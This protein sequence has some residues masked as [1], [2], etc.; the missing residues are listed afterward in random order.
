VNFGGVECRSYSCSVAARFALL[1]RASKGD[2]SGCVAE[3]VGESQDG[4]SPNLPTG[5]L[6]ALHFRPVP[7]SLAPITSDKFIFRRSITGG[8][9]LR[10]PNQAPIACVLGGTH[11]RR[12]FLTIA[13]FIGGVPLRILRAL[14]RNSTG[15]N[16]SRH[17]SAEDEPA[18]GRERC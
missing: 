7:E 16:V 14:M 6:Y 3:P 12:E 2:G 18:L 11:Q 1:A 5:W 13:R 17:F 4:T 9:P 8:N 15:H 10:H